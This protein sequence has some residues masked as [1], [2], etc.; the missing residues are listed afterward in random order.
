MKKFGLKMKGFSNQLPRAISCGV[1]SISIVSTD[2]GQWSS[3]DG[4]HHDWTICLVLT[5]LQASSSYGTSSFIVW[6]IGIDWTIVDRINIWGWI[7]ETSRVWS[8]SVIS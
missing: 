8:I 5:H 2:N 4:L 3:D 6:V 7:N 1:G